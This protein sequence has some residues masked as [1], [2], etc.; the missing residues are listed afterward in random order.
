MKFNVRIG[1]LLFVSYILMLLTIETA[2]AQEETYPFGKKGFKQLSMNM[3]PLLVQLLPLNRSGVRTGPYN[4]IFK[5]IG[6]KGRGLKMA[7][8]MNI[9]LD[10][11][12]EN[13]L[14]IQIGGER[15]KKVNDK[16]RYSRGISLIAY[17]GSFNTPSISN[18]NSD[19]GVGAGFTMGIEY[20]FSEHISLSTEGMWAIGTNSNDGFFTQVIPPISIFFNVNLPKK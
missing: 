4:F 20:L 10:N 8:G 15:V 12:D 1:V 2:Q 19:V 6:R 7:M 5:R 18:D 14:N 3:T 9:N 13:H 17:V 16:W 11:E